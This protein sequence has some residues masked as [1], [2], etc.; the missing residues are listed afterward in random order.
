MSEPRH[1]AGALPECAFPGG[2]W[3]MQ[4]AAVCSVRPPRQREVEPRWSAEPAEAHVYEHTLNTCDC[5]VCDCHVCVDWR[6]FVS[7]HSMKCSLG[8]GDFSIEELVQH[9]LDRQRTKPQPRTHTCLCNTA[10]GNAH[11]AMTSPWHHHGLRLT[12]SCMC[13][14]CLQVWT[15]LIAVT[16]P[17]TASSPPNCPPPPANPPPPPSALRGGR[18]LGKEGEEKPS[19]LT[20]RLR[21]AQPLLPAPPPRKSAYQLPL[22]VSV[23]KQSKT[24]PPPSIW[25]T[26]GHRSHDLSRTLVM[27][28]KQEVDHLLCSWLLSNRNSSE[29]GTVMVKSQR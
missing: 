13:V 5:S 7:V 17:S 20:S 15:F 25:H 19:C 9:I 28:C 22:P 14:Q 16:A 10:Q 4:S 26:W 12:C 27:W 29:G 2:F 24:N 6:L 18:Q 23:C 1:C 8:S 21:A 3:E 11:T